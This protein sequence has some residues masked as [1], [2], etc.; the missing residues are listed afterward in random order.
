M[1]TCFL[2]MILSILTSCSMQKTKG[3]SLEQA[4]SMSGENQAEL[5]KVLEYYKNDSIKLEAA[6]YLIR[7]MP[8]HFSRMEYFVSPEGER[9]VPD[10]RNFTDNQ[11]VKR[12]CDSL[13]EKGYTIRKEIVYDIKALHS[14][15]LIRNIDLAFQAWQKPWAKDISFEGFCRYILPYRAEVE[16]ASDMRQELMEYYLPLIDSGKARNAFEA[17]MIINKQFINDLKYK[18]TGQPFYPTVEET[19]R[20]GIGECDALCNFATMAMRAVGIPV[21]VQTTTWTKMDL[22]HS[23]CA[24]LQDGEFYDFSPAYA[25]PD[26]YRQKL[27]TVRY[28]KPAKV[29]RNLFDADFKKSRTDDGYTTYLKS[30]LLKDVTAE[31]GYPVLDLR[32]E[33][34]KEP[35]SA[36]SLVYLCAYNYYEWKPVAIGIQT[37][38]VC[39]FKDVVGNNIFI[40]AEGGKE[41][42]LRYI[43]APF[44]VDSSGHIWKFIPDKNKLVTQEL[45]IEKGKTP[46]NLHFWDVEKEYFISVSCDSITSDTTQLYTRIPDNAL[47]WYATSHR[48]LGQRVGFI[49]NGQLKRTWDFVAVWKPTLGAR[50]FDLNAT[51]RLEQTEI[52]RTPGFRKAKRGD[53]LVFN[54]PHPNGWDKIEMHI[55]KYYIKRCIGLPGD[56]L[57]I[58]NGRFRINGTNEPLGNMDSQERIGRTLPGEFPDGV[59]KAFPFDSV[60]SWNIRNFGPLYVPKAGDKVEM[61][62]ENYLLYRKLIAWEQK[63]EINYN[64]ST[65]FLN[66]E[67]IREYRFLKNYYFMAGDKGLNSQDSRYWGLLPEEYIVGKAAF[68]WKSVDPYTGQFRWDRFMKKIE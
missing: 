10:I 35:S 52:H 55:L 19:F 62:R 2:F 5:E 49:E 56:T 32:I 23:W 63:A 14:D 18:E 45:W 41:Q 67:P 20:A 60:I 21:V 22:A 33:A 24:V 50:L 17:C 43:T 64:D 15:Y 44:L 51:L 40:I 8:F 30:P 26:E 58:R 47:L 38:A 16:P 13:Q 4:L 31:S 54:F 48:A 25:G 1:K 59:Y 6:R 61:N 68:V 28:L 27:M 11:A 42:E 34:D 39:E 9:Y 65:V 7:N 36:E 46:R 53:V 57:S 3:V 29:Y 12:H 37:D 66:G